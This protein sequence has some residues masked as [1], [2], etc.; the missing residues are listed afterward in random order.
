MK[1]ALL[2][3]RHSEGVCV[4]TMEDHIIRFI[5]AILDNYVLFRVFRIEMAEHLV[6][7]VPFIKYRIWEAAFL[8]TLVSACH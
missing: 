6:E 8:H 5:A 3:G 1:M 2:P 4:L 7:C